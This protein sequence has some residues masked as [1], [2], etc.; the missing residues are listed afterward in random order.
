MRLYTLRGKPPGLANKIP[1]TGHNCRTERHTKRGEPDSCNG[2]GDEEDNPGEAPH[3]LP[4][5]LVSI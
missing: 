3:G 4:Q 5:G 2:F 1:K